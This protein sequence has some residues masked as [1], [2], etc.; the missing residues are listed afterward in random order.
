MEALSFGAFP[1]SGAH[2]FINITKCKWL[3]HTIH[4]LE[5]EENVVVSI[6]N[7]LEC[8]PSWIV[9]TNDHRADRA[10]KVLEWYCAYYE[11][12]K[13]FNVLV[14]PFEQLIKEP[15][16]CINYACS[17]Y[18]LEQVETI[19]FDLSTDFH[20]P[21]EDKSTHD[22]IISEMVDSPNY[23]KAM[24]LFEELAVPVKLS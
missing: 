2:F 15:L 3:R 13:Q 1:R 9:F 19:E 23:S 16:F 6:R 10:D 18:G 21:T 5:K 22:T 4:I 20:I 17:F 11:A 7:P 24:A 14:I 8:V 12:C